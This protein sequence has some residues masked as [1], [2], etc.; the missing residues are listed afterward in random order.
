V[1]HSLAVYPGMKRNALIVVLVVLAL[2]TLSLGAFY[3]RRSDSTPEITTAAVSRGSIVSEVA[4]TGTLEASSAV[5]VGSQVSGSVQA[6]YADFNSLVRRGQ[7][8]ARLEPSLYE[9]AIEQARA[10]LVKAEADLERLQLSVADAETKRGRSRALWERQLVSAN[11]M[12][13]AEVTLRLAGAQARSAEAQVTQVAASLKQAQV[14]LAKTVI[15]SPIDGI[16]VARNVD[17][18]QTVAASLQAPTLFVIAADLTQMRLKASIDESDVGRIAA[19]QSVEFTVDAYPGEPFKGIV[20]QVRLNPVVEQNV[21]TYAAII[22]APNPQLKLRPGMTANATVEISRRDDVLKLPA[23]ALRVR[24]DAAVLKLLGAEAAT[25][26]AKASGPSKG[27]AT[28]WISEGSSIRPVRVRTGVSD[29]TSV[30]IL[31][32]SIDEGARVVTRIGAT[33]SAQSTASP[34]TSRSPLM[35]GPIGPPPPR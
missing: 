35:T 11:D 3:A 10:N 15:L 17:V 19:G 33:A 26:D 21:V 22:S 30:E 7:V 1:R 4:A 24:P 6:L 13:A 18:G 34:T 25:P 2:T 8:L 20:E 12:D 14:N 32:G 27:T 5:E 28:L 31:D 23:A 16:V 9:S 29:A